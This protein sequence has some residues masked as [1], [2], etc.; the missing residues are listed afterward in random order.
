MTDEHSKELE[1]SKI[2]AEVKDP[3]VQKSN[4]LLE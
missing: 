3:K 1:S 2:G 4:T